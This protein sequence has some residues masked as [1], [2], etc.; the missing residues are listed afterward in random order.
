MMDRKW[1]IKAMVRIMVTSRTYRQTSV[2]TPEMLTRDP[3]NRELTRQG[4]Y[5]LDAE[6]VRDFALATSHLLVPQIGGPSVRPYQPDGYWENLNFPARNW[7]A[8][9]GE[10]QY[11]RG[12]YTWWQRMFLH[13][14]LLAFDASSR[15][16]CTAERT[17]SNIPQQALALLNDPSYVEAARALA[18]RVLHESPGDDASRITWLWLEALQR[19]PNEQEKTSLLTLLEKHRAE[20]H[21]DFP[22]AQAFGKVGSPSTSELDAAELAAWSSLTR[23]VLNLHEFITRS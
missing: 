17:R 10:S 2:A 20:F 6:F 23:V 22:A 21:T 13:P 4:R 19:P 8:S 14:S 18:V 15:E 3:E 16:E 7:N 1:N 5:R 11:R 9:T 12:L